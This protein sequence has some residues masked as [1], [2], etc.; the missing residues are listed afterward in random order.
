MN[1][2]KRNWRRYSAIAALALGLL[3]VDGE[4]QTLQNQSTGRV[5]NNGTITFTCPT[6]Q[7]QNDADLS[8]GAVDND[9]GVIQFTETGSATGVLQ[10][11]NIAGAAAGQALGISEANRIGGTVRYNGA[12]AQTIQGGLY[13]TNLDFDGSGNKTLDGDT[14]V[15]AGYTVTNGTP[16]YNNAGGSGGGTTFYYDGDATSD[17]TIYPDAYYSLGFLDAGVKTLADAT[18]ASTTQDVTIDG[19]TRAS[20]NV[21]IDGELT[22]GNS[23]T[24]EAGAG[25]LVIDNDGAG[26]TGTVLLAGANP[27]TL[28]ATTNINNAGVLRTT[29]AG[30]LTVSAT[31]GILNVNGGVFNLQAGDAD[32]DGTLAATATGGV[33]DVDNSRTLTVS[34][35]F[36]NAGDGTNLD[37]ADETGVGNDD[38]STVLYDGAAAQTVLATVASNPYGNLTVV[39]TAG[40][41]PGG[42]VYVANDWTLGQADFDMAANTLYM[43]D[44]VAD[45]TYN[46]EHEV[47]GSMNRTIGA[48]AGTLVYNNAFTSVEVTTNPGNIADMT[49][50][51]QPGGFSTDGTYGTHYDGDKDVNRLITY[52]YA[53]GATGW[54]ATLEFGYKKSEEPAY[55]NEA[56]GYDHTSLRMRELTAADVSEKVATGEATVD[57]YS[58][59]DFA[60]RSLALVDPGTSTTDLSQIADPAPLFLRGGPTTFIS[61]VSGRWS[62]PA[63][64]DEGIEPGANDDVI[65]ADG[66]Q[67]HTGGTAPNRDNYSTDEASE[68]AMASS[69]LIQG[70]SGGGG[71]AL[72]FGT[73]AAGGE[74]YTMNP[75]TTITVEDGSNT[76]PTT[77]T[78]FSSFLAT[79]PGGFDGRG[80]IIFNSS[81]GAGT[82]TLQSQNYDINGLLYNDGDVRVCD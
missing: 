79:N 69:V 58:G 73:D 17:Q 12:G 54:E 24:Q 72:I 9:N 57:D 56:A 26:G 39:N 18:V 63:T 76:M 16:V 77:A 46:T 36:T 74:A 64:W 60:S 55:A 31:T 33:I 75:G 51:V 47:I 70:D 49:L 41:A 19:T 30:L 1:F 45:A 78:D 62:N 4:A 50:N 27:S 5:V 42:D 8:T 37:F 44:N 2:F 25:D 35:S 29:G 66:T 34:G 32:I 43:T 59:T 82:T 80:L 48:G 11:T 65:I 20:G 6:G 67:V 13:F 52:D 68:A 14:Y 7:F 40:A 53:D 21:V 81:S 10:F 71:A 22:V 38:A 61:I 15:F 23:L 28:T 3:V